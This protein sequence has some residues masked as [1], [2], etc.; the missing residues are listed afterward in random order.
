MT[1]L[2]EV[3]RAVGW[4]RIVTL[5]GGVHEEV[6]LEEDAVASSQALP[7]G[8]TAPSGA[9]AV[10]RARNL[11]GLPERIVAVRQKLGL[12]QRPFAARIGVS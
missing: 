11:D 6:A 9:P 4:L 8:G 3:E 2:L 7:A 5:S 1:A 12:S 10:S